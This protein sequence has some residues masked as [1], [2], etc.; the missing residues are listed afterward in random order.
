MRQLQDDM[1]SMSDRP[2]GSGVN[3]EA[4]PES[5]RRYEKDRQRFEL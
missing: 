5:D 4:F 3:P 2:Q 1:A